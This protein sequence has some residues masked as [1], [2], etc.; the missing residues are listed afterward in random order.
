[1][2]TTLGTACFTALLILANLT[3]A[4]TSELDNAIA[5]PNISGSPATTKMRVE[6]LKLRHAESLGA[7]TAALNRISVDPSLVSAKE[8]FAAVDKADRDMARS[9]SAC[10]AILAAIRSEFTTINTD[11]AFSEEQKVELAATAKALAEQCVTVRNE[12][13]LVARNL[14]KAYKSLAA[15]KK[16]YRSYLNLQGEAQAKAKLNAAIGAYV[17]GLTEAPSEV[18]P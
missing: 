7:L 9:K 13:E 11:S 8:T 18:R 12:A 2:K 6:N 4:Q 3:N 17:K 14:T 1:M 16:V 5:D 15:A 10:D